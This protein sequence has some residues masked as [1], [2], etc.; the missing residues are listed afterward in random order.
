MPEPA[1]TIT[2][3]KYDLP[4]SSLYCSIK[5]PCKARELPFQG[6]GTGIAGPEVQVYLLCNTSP[7]GAFHVPVA[8][9]YDRI[10]LKISYFCPSMKK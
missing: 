2:V 7:R 9:H 1:V 6:I 8:F 5:L 3:D 4:V 10:V